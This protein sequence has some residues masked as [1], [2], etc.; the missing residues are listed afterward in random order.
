MDDINLLA[1]YADTLK[2]MQD[3]PADITAALEG[4]DTAQLGFNMASGLA[5]GILSGQSGVVSA[6]MAVT[7]AAL[8]A[9]R[10]SLGINS[11]SRVF[12]DEVGEMMMAGLGEGVLQ[13]TEEQ[14]KIIR[15][16]TRYLTGEAAGAAVVPVTNSKTMNSYDDSITFSGNEFSI[17]SEQDIRDLAREIAALTKRQ[18]AG[19]GTR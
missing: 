4:F 8:V 10:K 5:S 18:Q 14:A 19:K 12:R 13:S 17:R 9:A 11:P 2:A 15:N 16:A 1:A 3:I 6:M 7:E